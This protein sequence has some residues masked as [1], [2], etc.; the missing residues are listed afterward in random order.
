MSKFI[1]LKHLQFLLFD[2]H[3]L[4]D[5]IY[6]F[7][8]FMVGLLEIPHLL[9][10]QLPV[11]QPYPQHI[12]LYFLLVCYC[13]GIK[14]NF[15]LSV[16]LLIIL[17]FCSFFYLL[18]CLFDLVCRINYLEIF[19]HF[20]HHLVILCALWNVGCLFRWF[21]S[22]RRLWIGRFCLSSFF[23]SVF[24]IL[25]NLFLLLLL[26]LLFFLILSLCS[27]IKLDLLQ[28]DFSTL[29]SLLG[30]LSPLLF[31]SLQFL[32][33]AIIVLSLIKQQSKQSFDTCDKLMKLKIPRIGR[34][35]LEQQYDIIRIGELLV[36]IVDWYLIQFEVA[37]ESEE[38]FDDH[39]LV[40]VLYPIKTHVFARLEDVSAVVLEYFL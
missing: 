38:S 3:R 21:I 11:I 29:L 37:D 19:H 16:F 23:V 1:L 12:R 7:S 4:L 36:D 35:L 6:F 14:Y 40:F 8:V 34:T 31:L 17:L 33:P 26:F 22:L 2:F 25:Y 15:R 27:L 10:Y 32:L 18:H 39:V 9:L 28:L 30:L 13:V 5:W 24:W 20:L